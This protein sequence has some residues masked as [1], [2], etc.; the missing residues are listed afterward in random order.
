MRVR[1]LAIVLLT[2]IV[3]G[4]AGNPDTHAERFMELL[5]DGKHL[6]AQE[7]LSEDMSQMATLLGGV[8]D[9]SLNSYYQTGRMVEYS[10]TRTQQTKQAVRYKV[11]VICTDKK[12]YTDILDLKQENGKWRVSRF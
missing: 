3:C 7:Y 10:L 12:K 8:T 2:V 4:C 5:K 6:A 11:V 9:E 1:T